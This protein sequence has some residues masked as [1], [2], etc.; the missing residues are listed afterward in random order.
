MERIRILIVDDEPDFVD[1]MVRRLRDR[2]LD[3]VGVLS[4]AQALDLL[5]KRE[6]DVLLL[7][8]RMPG[9]DGFE[10]LREAKRKQPELG[11]IMLTG[12]S[13]SEL[14]AYG[15]DLADH[16][17]LVKPVPLDDL[18]TKIREAYASKLKMSDTE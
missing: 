2:N 16:N 4:G 10:T 6:F 3:A 15:L 8:L 13:A 1:P 9:I 17:Y 7:D 12:Q 11:V 18:L 14:G 5:D